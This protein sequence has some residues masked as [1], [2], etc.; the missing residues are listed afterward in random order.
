MEG[1]V[2]SQEA[3]RWQANRVVAGVTWCSHRRLAG[4]DRAPGEK[5][6]ERTAGWLSSD[7]IL[8]YSKLY[9]SVDPQTQDS[10]DSP[11]RVGQGPDNDPGARGPPGSF[12]AKSKAS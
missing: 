12:R 6:K 9:C 7:S 5:S 4:G 8:F 3:E 11:L 10:G 2:T 1:K